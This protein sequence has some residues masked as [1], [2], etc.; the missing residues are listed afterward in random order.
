MKVRDSFLLKVGFR[1]Y[2]I[3]IYI[4]LLFSTRPVR[5]QYRRRHY[6]H[7]RSETPHLPSKPALRPLRN[8]FEPTS[9]PLGSKTL[10]NTGLEATS[11]KSLGPLE[12][13]APAVKSGLARK[14]MFARERT[15]TR[16]RR[17]AR[18][19]QLFERPLCKICLG[20]TS[21]ASHHSA[22]LHSVR[23]THGFTLV[24]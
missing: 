9:R 18:K 15:F 13:T 1:V 3:Y 24:Y 11:S 20:V 23:Y 14:R 8:H 22:S 2:Y 17:F 12:N 10:E 4:Y 19:K 16:I 21:P 5:L 6:K 7:D